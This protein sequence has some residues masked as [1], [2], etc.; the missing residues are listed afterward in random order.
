MGK[1]FI[2]LCM[3]SSI[4]SIYCVRLLLFGFVDCE[5]TSNPGE[6][7]SSLAL[8]TL[9]FLISCAAFWIDAFSIAA[10]SII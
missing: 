7:G 4:F 6:S 3:L 10:F 5:G 1:Y 8:L 9:T 2:L